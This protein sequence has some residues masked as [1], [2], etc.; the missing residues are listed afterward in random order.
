MKRLEQAKSQNEIFQILKR[1]A[2]AF[3]NHQSY[4]SAVKRYLQDEK[5]IKELMSTKKNL[6]KK[7]YLSK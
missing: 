6:D 7:I 3:D 5:L 1:L 2:F 4:E